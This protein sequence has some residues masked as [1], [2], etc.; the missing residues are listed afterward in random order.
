MSGCFNTWSVEL[1]EVIEPINK[2]N[3]EVDELGADS[4]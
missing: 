1:H 3:V 2:K 4:D